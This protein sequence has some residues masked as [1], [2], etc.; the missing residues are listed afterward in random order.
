M[1]IHGQ[2]GDLSFAVRDQLD[3]NLKIQGAVLESV[4]L[5]QVRLESA[6]LLVDEFYLSFQDGLNLALDAGFVTEADLAREFG[7]SRPTVERWRSGHNAPTDSGLRPVAAYLETACKDL[8]QAIH[9]FGHVYD[10]EVLAEFLDILFDAILK[11]AETVV[12]VATILAKDHGSFRTCQR[13]RKQD[14]TTQ[15][16]SDVTLP[17][18]EGPC[19]DSFCY[20]RCTLP[21]CRPVSVH[22]CDGCVQALKEEA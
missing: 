21:A 19:G 10:T 14:E 17:G 5:G 22:L 4:V 9:W 7:A 3:V 12:A 8:I 15:L 6:G 11:D 18:Y 13:C 16:R 1:K 2:P 20:A